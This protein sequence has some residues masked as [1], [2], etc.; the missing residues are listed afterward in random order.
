MLYVL[1]AIFIFLETQEGCIYWPP[2]Y[3]DQGHVTALD[4][5]L[6]GYYAEQLY[7][8]LSAL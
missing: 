6:N 3:L 5:L 8:P 7:M 4:S 1:Q 2:L